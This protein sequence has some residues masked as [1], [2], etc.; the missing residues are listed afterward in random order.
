MGRRDRLELS[1]VSPEFGPGICENKMEQEKHNIDEIKK[2]GTKAVFFIWI[3]PILSLVLL[4]AVA[5]IG[6]HFLEQ[7]SSI[8]PSRLIRIATISIIVVVLFIIAGFLHHYYCIRYMQIPLWRWMASGF[9]GE[10]DLPWLGKLKMAKSISKMNKKQKACMWLGRICSVV[11]TILI[12]NGV[13]WRWIF[14]I[15]GERNVG[16][17]PSKLLLAGAFILIAGLCIIRI[18]M[19]TG[20]NNRAKKENGHP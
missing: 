2:T 12:I 10:P 16:R 17:M 14:T 18:S 7:D 3:L 20:N 15:R 19:P 9:K 5:V 6:L 11:G 13:V 8:S 1:M 4:T